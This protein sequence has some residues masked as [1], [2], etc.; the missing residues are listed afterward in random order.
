MERLTEF[1]WCFILAIRHYM[2]KCN[3]ETSQILFM[4]TSLWI[5]EETKHYP[6]KY[7]TPRI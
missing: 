3:N 7:Q 6:Q 2:T 4:N 1:S 5:N